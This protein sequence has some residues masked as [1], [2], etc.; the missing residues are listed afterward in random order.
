MIGDKQSA[1][2][3][4]YV[5]V[6]DDVYAEKQLADAPEENQKGR[7][8]DGGVEGFHAGKSREPKVGNQCHQRGKMTNNMMSGSGL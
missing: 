6:T 2:L 3:F 4:R 1:S 8:E 7:S 5:R